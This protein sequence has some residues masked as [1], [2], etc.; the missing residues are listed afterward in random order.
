MTVTEGLFTDPLNKQVGHQTSTLGCWTCWDRLCYLS[1]SKHGG[2]PI[3]IPQLYVP[4]LGTQLVWLLFG[5]FS[6]KTFQWPCCWYIEEKK[7]KPSPFCHHHLSSL[8]CA[9]FL[10]LT[11][12]NAVK[13][14]ALKTNS[15]KMAEFTISF[16]VYIIHSFIHSRI[17]L[18]M[19][20]ICPMLF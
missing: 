12:K 13:M 4:S 20:T 18:W 5:F 17:I 19:S 3:T 1:L 9:T 8:P 6:S 11:L 7:K 10:I 15:H 2:N 16:F 14:A